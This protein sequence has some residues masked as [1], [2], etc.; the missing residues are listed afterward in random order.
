MVAFKNTIKRIIALLL[1]MLILAITMQ[2]S[3]TLGAGYVTKKLHPDDQI[4]KIILHM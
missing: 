3:V 1:G 4:T 2:P